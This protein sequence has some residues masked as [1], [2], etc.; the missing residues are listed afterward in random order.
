MP[1]SQ[2]LQGLDQGSSLRVQEAFS[3]SAS[4]R[5]PWVGVQH[6]ISG[7]RGSGEAH[8][9]A[10]LVGF[11]ALRQRLLN[12]DG[13]ADAVLRRAQ[14]QLHLRQMMPIISNKHSQI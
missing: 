7:C 13:A 9:Q 12:V 3:P 14:R 4:V 8:Q 11:N 10:R 1:S 5:R 2:R 6:I